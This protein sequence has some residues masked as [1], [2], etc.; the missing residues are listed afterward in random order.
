MCGWLPFGSKSYDISSADSHS[1]PRRSTSPDSND[2]RAP[3][4]RHVARAFVEFCGVY[5]F[6]P[7]S[8]SRD[9]SYGKSP[10]NVFDAVDVR[11]GTSFAV[12]HPRLGIVCI[13][14]SCSRSVAHQILVYTRQATLRNVDCSRSVIASYSH[15]ADSPRFYNRRLS[16]WQ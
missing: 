4:T 12:S 8:N 7:I 15:V 6:D 14:D 3:L 11:D 9:G 1:K 10:E 5:C 13:A 16:V 2:C